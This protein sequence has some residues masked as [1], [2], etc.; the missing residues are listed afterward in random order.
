MVGAARLIFLCFIVNSIRTVLLVS[1][2]DLS[3][4][5]IIIDIKKGFA[6]RRIGM[7]S[8]NII[9]E[10]VHTFIPIDNFCA[11]SPQT[12][13]CVYGS[14]RT[15][16]NVVPLATTMASRNTIHTLASYTSERVAALINKDVTR[17]L[18]Q[19]HPDEILNNVK[20]A[21]FIRNEVY[22]DKNDDKTLATISAASTIHSNSNIPLLQPTPIEI[23]LK[24]ISNNKIGFEYLSQKDLEFFLSTVFSI[25]DNSYTISNAYESLDTFS[26]YI[27]GQSVLALRYCSM[28]PLNAETSQ[29]CIVVS[30]LFTRIPNDD[31]SIYMMYRL[32]PLPTI[33]NDE[34]FIYTN[35][36]KILGINVINERFMM[37]NEDTDD[38]QCLM[39]T[40][41][42]CKRMPIS[43]S[44]SNP[45]CVSQLLDERQTVTTMCHVSRSSYAGQ[46]ILRIADGLW[47]FNHIERPKLCTVYLSAKESMESINI[48]E[49]SIIATSCGKTVQCADVQLPPSTC[50]KRRISI[51]SNIPFHAN[52][53]QNFV[54]PIR[55]LT[56]TLVASYHAQEKYKREEITT[57]I[58]SKKS[59]FNQI[60]QEIGTYILSVCFLILSIICGYIIKFIKYTIEREIN[61][62]ET[63]LETVIKV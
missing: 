21:H 9:E 51:I 46:N 11:T 50:T 30:T 49:T 28:V 43:I 7:Y 40:I 45:S 62:I 25:I 20:M 39:S 60:T 8:A 54:L 18:S 61:N 10:I 37:W 63:L 5:D 13:I 3:K 22:Y 55:N 59:M 36:P 19:H 1:M 58:T 6:L 31:K 57:Y 4:S 24:Q 2:Q 17:V 52:N 29:P 15:R 23:I 27:L 38:N 16:T 41:V 33:Y 56:E 14:L 42:H 53:V 26:D 32:I 44:L 12:N 48:I 47:Y 35:L 34:T